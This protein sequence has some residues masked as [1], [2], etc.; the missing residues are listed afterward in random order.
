MISKGQVSS[1][2][3]Q[4]SDII[5]LKRFGVI[6]SCPINKIINITM[7]NI[8]FQRPAVIYVLITSFK[9]ISSF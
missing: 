7:E 4:F 3:L 2:S 9:L 5:R 8:G 6:D 1:E